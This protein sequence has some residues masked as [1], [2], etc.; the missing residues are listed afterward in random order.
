MVND[1]IRS[2]PRFQMADF[3]A[4]PHLVGRGQGSSWDLLES[5]CCLMRAI[6]VSVP[7]TLKLEARISME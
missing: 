6:H 4:Y 7:E 5:H 2:S 3:S 1:D